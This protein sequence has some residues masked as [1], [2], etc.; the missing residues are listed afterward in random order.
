MWGG[1][2]WRQISQLGSLFKMELAH[3]RCSL[4]EARIIIM[5]TVNVCPD[6]DL[7]RT[8]GGPD[9]R[10]SVV[11]AASLKIVDLSFIIASYEARG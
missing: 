4:N 10:G 8:E 5:H 11:A 1:V 2:S 9:K 7:L 3:G 6:L